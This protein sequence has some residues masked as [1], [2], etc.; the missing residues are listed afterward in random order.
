[1][2]KKV[3]ATQNLIFYNMGSSFTQA[4]LVR[5]STDVETVKDSKV[6]HKNIHVTD[7][8]LYLLII[9]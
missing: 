6:E 9:Y 5:F 3:N 1:M 2:D 7:I 4:A 8:L